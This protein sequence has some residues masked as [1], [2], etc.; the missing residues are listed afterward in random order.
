MAPD[1]VIDY[2]SEI[3][4]QSTNR[5]DTFP[6]VETYLEYV[7]SLRD[8]PDRFYTN[9]AIIYIEKLFTLLPPYKTQERPLK[10]EVFNM[11]REKLQSFLESKSQYNSATLLEKIKGTWMFDEEILLLIKEDRHKEAI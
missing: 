4:R 7:V 9:L 11:Y 5:D 2:L 8:A 10:R 3:E 1:E 6:Y